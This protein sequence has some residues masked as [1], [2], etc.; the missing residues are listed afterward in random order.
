VS[1]LDL[2]D[3][4]DMRELHQLH[5][6]IREAWRIGVELGRS[7]GNING[8][9]LRWIEFGLR[10]WMGKIEFRL[11]IVMSEYVLDRNF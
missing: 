11:N 6:V 2:G 9:K 3:P 5:H 10:F 1:G 8:L 7:N 4:L